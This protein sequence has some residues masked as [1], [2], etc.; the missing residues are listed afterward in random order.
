MDTLDPY[1]LFDAINN[2][3]KT[4]KKEE[5]IVWDIKQKRW[6]LFSVT[7]LDFPMPITISIGYDFESERLDVSSILMYGESKH[8]KN[9]AETIGQGLKLLEQ[10]WVST[11]KPE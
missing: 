10:E 2:F 7:I 11:T 4:I 9:I 8:M 1:I 6:H 5:R 3:K